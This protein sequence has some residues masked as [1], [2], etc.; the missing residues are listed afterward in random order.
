MI[1]ITI[2]QLALTL[3]LGG[4]VSERAKERK[5]SINQGQKG[6]RAETGVIFFFFLFPFLSLREHVD[7]DYYDDDS[8]YVELGLGLGDT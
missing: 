6:R 3:T 5:T 4:I 7:H 1:A 8:R 2:T